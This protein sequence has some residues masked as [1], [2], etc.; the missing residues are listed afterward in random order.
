MSKNSSIHRFQIRSLALAVGLFGLILAG[1][2]VGSADAAVPFTISASPSLSP[3]FSPLIHDYVVSCDGNPT[4]TITTT[5]KGSLLIGAQSLSSPL[6]VAVPLVVD[7]EV[8]VVRGGQ[9]FHIRCLPAD[10]PAYSA[11]VTGS[12][13]SQGY[14]VTPTSF[15]TEFSSNYTISFSKFGVPVWWYQDSG[16]AFNATYF[17][18]STPQIGW[19]TGTT[20][21]PPG[22]YGGSFTIRNLAGEVTATI[23]DPWAGTAIDAHDFQLLPNGN[24]LAIQYVSTTTDLSSWGLSAT[25]PILDCLVV[26]LNPSGQV[27]WSWSANAHINAASANENFRATA[28]DVFHMNSVHIVKRIVYLSFRHL[29]AVYAISKASGAIKW[30]VGGSATPQSLRVI[31]N[32]YPTVL[33]GQH[34]ARMRPD[35]SLSVHDNASNEPGL[36]P[37]GLRF[38]INTT[39]KT[40]TIV[41]QVTDPLL[42]MG[43]VCC[44]SAVKLGL[45]NWLVAWGGSPV[46]AELRPDGTSV[47]RITFPNRF[48]YRVAPSGPLEL[49]RAGMDARF[50]LL[51]L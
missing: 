32:T 30:K 14:L 47:V 26:E 21:G 3:S 1:M 37:R 4:T 10:F 33:S 27:V 49:L 50:P 38:V 44:G 39:A 28:P 42:G 23:G 25:E 13:Q 20:L 34:D 9:A 8:N 40:A 51:K 45:S 7:Q 16:Q 46:V 2:P 31:G 29:D 35:G 24:Y 5:G 6:S 15:T 17:A 36:I 18:G 11:S 22:T 41:E 19:F 12:A 43:S 48:S